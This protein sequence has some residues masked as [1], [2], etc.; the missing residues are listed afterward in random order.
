[1]RKT[2]PI[3][4]YYNTVEWHFLDDGSLQ[5]VSDSDVQQLIPQSQKELVQEGEKLL[6]HLRRCAFFP[7]Q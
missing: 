6:R 2:S 5:R 1:M 3:E 7:R 4:H